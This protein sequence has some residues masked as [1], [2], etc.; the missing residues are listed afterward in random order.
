M[1]KHRRQTHGRLTL[2]VKHINDARSL[3]MMPHDKCE[4]PGRKDHEAWLI[5]Q[6][7]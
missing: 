4:F 6:D 2:G 7:W 5:L 3:V 1:Y